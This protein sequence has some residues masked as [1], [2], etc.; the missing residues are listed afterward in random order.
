[1]RPDNERTPQDWYV[2]AER[3]HVEEHQGCPCCGARHCVFCSQWGDRVEYHCTAC[4]FSASRDPR[5]GRHFTTAETGRER[6]RTV[7]DGLARSSRKR[8]PA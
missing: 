6:P 8:I 1:M 7:L 2:E 4:D 5:T 3:C